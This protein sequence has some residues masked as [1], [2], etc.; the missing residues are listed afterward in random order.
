MR[1]EFKELDDIAYLIENKIKDIESNEFEDESES[2]INYW[3]DLLSKTLKMRN[4]E[5]NI[6]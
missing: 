2:E 1:F 5:N 6:R 3:N 4:Q